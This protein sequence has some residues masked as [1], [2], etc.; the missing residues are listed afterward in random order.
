MIGGLPSLIFLDDR[1]SN[2]PHGGLHPRPTCAYHIEHVRTRNIQH[3][4][5]NIFYIVQ[6]CHELQEPCL[7][8]R[9]DAKEV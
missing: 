3:A 7:E 4:H 6:V 9:G 1:W 8:A 5:K 2:L